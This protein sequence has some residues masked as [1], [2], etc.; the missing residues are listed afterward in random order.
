MNEQGN[1][2]YDPKGIGSAFTKY[3]QRLF[4]SSSPTNIMTC[5]SALTKKV[6]QFVKE[7]IFQMAMGLAF[8]RLIGLLL[9]MRYVMQ[10]CLF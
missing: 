10:C 6:T 2:F 4:T 3:Y 5:L 1:M 7:A 9:V 8:I